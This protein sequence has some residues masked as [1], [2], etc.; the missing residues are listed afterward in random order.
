VIQRKW[1]GSTRSSYGWLQPETSILDSSCRYATLIDWLF[2]NVHHS[3]DGAFAVC[4]NS[5]G[6]GEIAFALSNWGLDSLI[7]VAVL[8]SGPPFTRL[9]YICES[10]PDWSTSCPS[11][12]LP[13]NV[14][15]DCAA[16]AASLCT[17]TFPSNFQFCTS[18]AINP[19]VPPQTS[20]LIANSLLNGSEVL[21]YSTRVH[22]ILGTA[23]CSTP[24]IPMG[25]L[26]FDA[27]QTEKVMQYVKDGKHWMPETLLGRRA[28][29]DAL[30]AGTDLG[31]IPATVSP[32]SWPV[33]G[34]RFELN[35]QGPP[36]GSVYIGWASTANDMAWVSGAG[37]SFLDQSA[38]LAFRLQLDV[39]SGMAS[40]STL[41]PVDM[42]GT[43]LYLQALFIAPDS[44]IRLSNLN[45][46]YVRS[47]P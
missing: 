19:G 33:E 11:P 27:I 44:T 20:E 40:Y 46:I 18:S 26:F 2:Q 38:N 41:S 24:G 47:A 4:G 8:T 14:A 23:D 22:F 36:G 1:V 25:Q 31:A 7:D 29:V 45:E 42:A 16:G 39:G 21:S 17:Q 9:D 34:T 6:S 35:V 10:P 32:T 3:T 5:G 43:Q 37:W 12:L 30:L 15:L 28:I 13:A